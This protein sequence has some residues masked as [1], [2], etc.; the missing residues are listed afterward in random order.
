[1]ENSNRKE[2]DIFIGNQIAKLLNIK[3]G[4]DGRCNTL[5][6]TKTVE[7]LGAVITRIVEDSVV[8]FGGEV[9]DVKPVVKL[10]NSHD[11]NGGVTCSGGMRIV[12]NN[13]INPLE[14]E[15]CDEIRRD[16]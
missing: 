6:G 12:C 10:T 7:G 1:M 16:K 11:L 3:F 2:R 13:G 15:L 9:I 5:W 4:S 14:D 8:Q